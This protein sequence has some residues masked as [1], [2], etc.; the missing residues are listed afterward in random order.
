MGALDNEPSLDVLQGDL[1]VS[2]TALT[3]SIKVAA[4]DLSANPPQSTGRYYR[5]YFT[6]AGAEYLLVAEQDTTMQGV[7]FQDPDGV[8]VCPGCTV[9]FDQSLATITLVLPLATLNSSVAA[10]SNGTTPPVGPGAGISGLEIVAQRQLS[11]A[12]A[13]GVTPTADDAST[14]VTY[15]VPTS[16][17]GT[18]FGAGEADDATVI[19][20]I[21]S[22]IAPY[23]WD[24]L[25]SKMPQHLDADPA[26]D[27]PLSSPPDTWLSGFPSPG[28]FASYSPLNLTL[29]GTN[30]GAS[31]AALDAAD[32]ATW[33]TVQQSTPGNVNY[34][35]IPGT[36]VIGAVSFT[37]GQLHGDTGQHGVGVTSVSTGNLHGT[38]PECLLVFI[39]HGPDTT[40]EAAIQWAES[41]PWIDVLT[42][43]YGINLV[44]SNTNGVVRDNIYLGGAAL[45]SGKAASQRGQT[46][47]WSAGNGIEN[48]FV[49]PNSTYTTSLKG[50]DWI[51][52]V[53]A[54]TPPTADASYTGS[55]KPVDL[56]GVGEGYPSAYTAT[57]VSGTGATGFS[58]TSNATP[59]IA[60]HYARALYTARRDFAGPS[61]AQ[62]G[63]VIAQG[64]GPYA[65]GA[66]RPNCELADGRLTAAELRNR[67]LLGATHRFG[68]MSVGGLLPIP[69]LL[70]TEYA[71]VGHGVYKAR[72]EGLEAAWL[73]EFDRILGP[74][75][76]RAFAAPRP[77]GESSW[78]AVD[79][80]CRQKLWGSGQGGYY[81]GHALPGPAAAW[82]LRTALLNA[83]KVLPKLP[84]N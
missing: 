43:S 36:K 28:S 7:S 63:G 18:S 51:M 84:T 42:N 60:G 37:G 31:V 32:A 69:N 9:D 23:H 25:A 79:S 45:A 73:A 53:G 33:S 61:R 74:L 58:G 62:S 1:S 11:V 17:T 70:D 82:P 38:C 30:P 39:Q 68:G 21:D 54:S 55:G 83:C 20:V 75:E 6:Y 8:V 56:A 41:Q 64:S 3:A 29:D 12:G 24:F 22:A 67:L 52:T 2:A 81:P 80:F 65:C 49:V 14:D 78:M 16:A 48:A 71:N 44:G 13:G 27:L 72:A 15:V 40:T 59:T 10:L 57:S 76:G 77:A 19:A 26:N 35:W 4:L 5:W 46:I 47:F 66:K 34:Y 50:P